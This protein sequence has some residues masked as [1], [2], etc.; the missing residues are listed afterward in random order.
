MLML[1][2]L[3]WIAQ[4]AV[5]RQS[6]TGESGGEI[7]FSPDVKRVAAWS[8]ADNSI[9]AWSLDDAARSSRFAPT[10]CVL[11]SLAFSP[12]SQS[13]VSSASGVVPDATRI[14]PGRIDLWELQGANKS[15]RTIFVNDGAIAGFGYVNPTPVAA[16]LRKS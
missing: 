8:S 4:I 15:K 9:S 10:S 3:A 12:D 5:E 2:G 7:V 16:V 1:G 11:H 14:F 13:L 6:A